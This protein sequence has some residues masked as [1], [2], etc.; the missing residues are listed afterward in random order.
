MI[1]TNSKLNLRIFAGFS[2]ILYLIAL[3]LS[4]VAI[5]N[6]SILEVGTDQTKVTYGMFKACAS[7]LGTLICEKWPSDK[8]PSGRG[9]KTL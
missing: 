9:I 6:F 4:L 2:I 5:L 7:F 3:I 1:T 8:F